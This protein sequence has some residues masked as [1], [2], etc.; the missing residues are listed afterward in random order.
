LISYKI[1]NNFL[2]YLFIF[3]LTLVL[4]CASLAPFPAAKPFSQQESDRLISNLQDQEEKVLSFQGVGKLMLK[5]GQEEIEANL[6]AIG[7]NPYKIRLE[8]THPWGRPLLYIV[9]DEK[10]IS[11]LSL[12]DKKFFRG[13]PHS[14]DM[15]QFFLY[16]LDL[17]L[18]WK[19]FSGSVP[20][21]STYGRT[22]SL[23]P[24]EISLYNKQG[25]IIETISF[26]SK[27]LLPRSIYFPKKGL[28]I[29]L[30][31]FDEGYLGPHPL[32][33]KI[34]KESEDQLVVIRYKSFTLNKPV[35]EEIFQLNPPPSFEIV[36]LN[37]S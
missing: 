19:I 37:N 28:S 29:L 2:S 13:P 17:D 21:L 5:K 27:T 22:M 6:F 16:G 30:S 10:S 3:L 26:S 33:I 36:N 34:L 31:E 14:L 9:A 18:A 25:E 12:T 8:I 4:G 7:S 35:P 11:I 24:H 15:K 32:Q 23:K 20:I 1:W